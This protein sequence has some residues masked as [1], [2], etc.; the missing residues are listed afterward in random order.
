MRKLLLCVLCLKSCD[1]LAAELLRMAPE[2]FL[3]RKVSATLASSVTTPYKVKLL[4]HHVESGGMV[5]APRDT[6]P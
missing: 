4:V 5:V 1:L 6:H 3:Q 2:L